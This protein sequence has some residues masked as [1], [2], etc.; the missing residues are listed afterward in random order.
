MPQ[1]K[2][3]HILLRY[4]EGNIPSIAEEYWSIAEMGKLKNWT[5]RFRKR[6][7]HYMS[8]RN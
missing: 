7:Q 6:R 2:W 5:D 4:K 1:G 8:C 3:G